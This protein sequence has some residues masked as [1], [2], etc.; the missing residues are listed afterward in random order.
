MTQYVLGFVFNSGMRNIVLLLNKKKPSYQSGK[1]NGVGGHVEPGE[2]PLDAM[3]R[4]CLEEAGLDIESWELFCVGNL[5]DGG[6]VRCYRAFV[7]D[8]TARNHFTDTGEKVGIYPVNGLDQ[9]WL[10]PQVAWLIPLALEE[11]VTSWVD[12]QWGQQS[13]D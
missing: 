5:P 1:M 10:A 4:E 2:K 12:V 7:D 6:E 13:R 11:A 3:R 8:L 9:E